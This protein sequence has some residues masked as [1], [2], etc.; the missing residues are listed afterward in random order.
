[1]SNTEV[2]VSTGGLDRQLLD[3]VV[4]GL[5]QWQWTNHGVARCVLPAGCLTINGTVDEGTTA[6]VITV[7]GDCGGFGP[8]L[9]KRLGSI[10]VSKQGFCNFLAKGQYNE[11]SLTSLAVVPGSIFFFVINEAL[12]FSRMVQIETTGNFRFVVNEEILV[13]SSG[14][15]EARLLYVLDGGTKERTVIIK[16]D[17]I[18]VVDSYDVDSYWSQLAAIGFLPE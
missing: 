17:G 13:V 6:R 7:S 11:W 18:V 10:G 3:E 9:I 8:S 12:L 15:G 4:W 14:K 1:M 2:L 5:P 16:N